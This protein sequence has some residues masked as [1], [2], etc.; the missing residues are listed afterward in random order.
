MNICFKRPFRKIDDFVSQRL[1][2]EF[3]STP[4]VMTEPE[5]RN[6]VANPFAFRRVFVLVH[7]SPPPP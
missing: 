7:R 3:G 5:R 6:D 4:M 1:N 2:L